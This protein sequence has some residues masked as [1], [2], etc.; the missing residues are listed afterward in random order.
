M[1]LSTNVFAEIFR[2]IQPGSTMTDIRKLFPGAKITLVNT[3]WATEGE[4]LYDV[5]GPGLPGSM[6]IKFNDISVVFKKSL[7]TA[8]KK[9]PKKITKTW[10]YLAMTQC[11]L[12]GLEIFPQTIFRL[13]A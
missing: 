10:Q 11:M 4:S 7:R 1:L 6:K 5:S 3:A 2:G 8:P 9:M 12:N 13:S